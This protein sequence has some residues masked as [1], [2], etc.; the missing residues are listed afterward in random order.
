MTIGG[1]NSM[2]NGHLKAFVERI[3]RVEEQLRADQE[4][5]KEIYQEAKSS[6]FDPKVIRKIVAE[7]RQDRAKLDEF[8][9]L[10]ELYRNAVGAA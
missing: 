4:D 3:E 8:E 9:A 7:R 2:D 5:R 10:L 6:G 1:S